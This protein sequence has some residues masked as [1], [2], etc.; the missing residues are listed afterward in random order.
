LTNSVFIN[1]SRLTK[2]NVY[3]L[4]KIRKSLKWKVS[5]QDFL[6]QWIEEKLD[7]EEKDDEGREN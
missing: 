3:R 6:N 4:E 1:Y 5:K 2:A 7:E